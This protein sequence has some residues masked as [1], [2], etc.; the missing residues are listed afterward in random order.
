M[1]AK[2]VDDCDHTSS[3]ATHTLMRQA[4][5]EQASLVALQMAAPCCLMG[6]ACMSTDCPMC[7]L[8]TL[9]AVQNDVG[10]ALLQQ[11]GNRDEA[12]KAMGTMQV[13]VGWGGRAAC[14][15]A[16]LRPSV[17]LGRC[18]NVSVDSSSALHIPY[19]HR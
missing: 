11:L 8:Y 10:L 2:A 14:G 3:I 16:R 19:I 1:R 9:P 6:D 12:R 4:E 5:T 18:P 7:T 13:R 17:C 15:G